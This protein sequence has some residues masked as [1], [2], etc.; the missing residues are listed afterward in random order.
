MSALLSTLS[1]V[2]I[3]ILIVGGVVVTFIQVLGVIVGDA[4]MVVFAGT[5]L[6]EPVCV[7]AGLAGVFAF[8]RM[9]TEEGKADVASEDIDTD[10]A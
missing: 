10:E 5:S 6:F 8:L 1:R 2:C 7:I 3:V 9:Y 4:D